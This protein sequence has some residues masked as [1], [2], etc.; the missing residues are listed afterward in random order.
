MKLWKDSHF[1]QAGK[2][3]DNFRIDR[4]GELAVYEALQEQLVAHKT[5]TGA[6]FME[7][8]IQR[9]EMRAI[10]NK[11]LKENG[12]KII[13]S[14]ETVRSW[15]V[16]KNKRSMQ[17]KQHRGRGLFSHR[18]PKKNFV[19]THMN[20]HYNRAHI[21]NYTRFF[22]AEKSKQTL[23][24]YTLRR[25]FDD[26]AYLR[27]GTAEGFSRPKNKPLL[28]EQEKLELPSYDFPEKCGYIAPG[29]NLIIHDME[30]NNV[31][32]RDTFSV[33]NVTV[34]VTCKPKLVYSSSATNWANDAYMDRLVF[35]EAHNIPKSG[36]QETRDVLTNLIFLKDSLKQ[37][38]LMNIEKD[39]IKCSEGGDF[40]EREKTR[41]S[42]LITRILHTTT[43]LKESKHEQVVSLI[44]SCKELLYQLQH[45]EYKISRVNLTEQECSKMFKE[46][47][48]L[49]EL[50][51]KEVTA[52]AP[53]L[54][55]CDFQTTDAGPG[56]GT[57]ERMVRNRLTESFLINDLDLLARFHYAPRD[58]KTH[59]VEQVM[60]CLN[61]ALGDGRFVDI[62]QKSLF[63]TYTEDKILQMKT[64]DFKKAQENQEVATAVS[65]A[66]TVSHR[67]EGTPCMFTTINSRVAD[68]QGV[69]QHF[70]FDQKY[71][72]KLMACSSEKAMTKCAGNHYYKFLENQFSL[73]FIRYKNGVE[74]I[75][76]DQ[77]FRTPVQ[78]NRIP[79][80][81]PN[82]ETLEDDGSWHYFKLN[83]ITEEQKQ[84]SADMPNMFCPIVQLQKLVDSQGEP[85]VAVTSTC[86]Q[87]S[88]KDKNETW[89]KISSQLDEFCEKYTGL[90]L[91]AVVRREAEKLYVRKLKQSSKKLQ[92]MNTDEL[93][94]VVTGTLKLQIKTSS[95]IKAVPWNG[96]FKGNDMTNTCTVDNMLFCCHVLLTHRPD[97]VETFR[98]SKNKIYNLLHQIHLLFK[99]SK[100]AEGKFQWIKQFPNQ[101][102][103]SGLIKT[104]NMWGGENDFFF[105]KMS[106]TETVYTIKCSNPSCRTPVN[107]RRSRMV[108]FD[109]QA[110]TLEEGITLWLENSMNR[111]CNNLDLQ[112]NDRCTGSSSSS[113]RVFVNGSPLILPLDVGF[114][115]WTQMPDQIAL[116]NTRYT[117]QALTYGN[118]GHFTSSIRIQ[119]T[120][121]LY[122]G[123]QE[124]HTTG[125]GIT[126]QPKPIP[127]PTY[128]K[129][130]AVYVKDA[131]Q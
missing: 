42:V 97:I 55:P 63:E 43:K 44:D 39:Y 86:D 74:G 91:F 93:F 24:G 110:R 57:S 34:S 31:K 12:Q 1:S 30:E 40:L 7:K 80:P 14:Y 69:Y 29:V 11:W 13:K 53:A 78:I 102:T 49:V 35:S 46:L 111:P 17:S 27:C 131:M 60:S 112:T 52:L 76:N 25:C 94:S 120:W 95:P 20:I 83:E 121:Y 101:S 68:K 103:T 98:R 100:F 41:L 127:P 126:K 70:Y 85:N 129:S 3:K 109:E 37:F 9:R 84:N 105:N 77:N 116:A 67:Y 125:N 123:L 66:K 62:D 82:Y 26:K 28:I 79:A 96:T 118:G 59:K 45:V 87:V 6:P 61:D 38:E 117:I 73:H 58:S 104:W 18:K 23:D 51:L 19:D 108:C 64:S 21:K 113:A 90:D 130:H 122:D 4:R 107:M 75:R 119:N 106:D 115:R 99:D 36:L 65:C 33:K 72:E 8:R 48:V 56:V 128:T 32:G 5:R 81:V 89:E 114:C 88:V 22:F 2:G 50:I 15:G 124:Y 71:A 47:H 54:R 92:K 16:A 10:A